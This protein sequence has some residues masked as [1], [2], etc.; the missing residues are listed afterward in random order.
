MSKVV[1]PIEFIVHVSPEYA[2]ETRIDLIGENGEKLY[3][4]I[5]K[6]YSNI[7]YYSRVDEKIKFH[8]QGAAEI[9]RLQISTF[10][11]L[12][13]VQAFN[14]VRLLLQAVGENEFTP[15][16][17]IQDRINLRHPMRND[18]INGGYLSIT[19]EYNPA[20]D[21]PVELVLLNEQGIVLGSCLYQFET[22][23]GRYQP[24]SVG[25]SYTLD[26]VAPVQLVIRQ[27][28]DRIEGLAYLYSIPLTIGP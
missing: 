11:T 3:E 4:N 18:Q 10:D 14:S 1:S 2:G 28:D 12:G 9:A 6:T 5:F 19:G 15:P 26:K 21:Q 17:A 8:I 20:N 25:F 22:G 13:R 16:F 24:F 7:G 27:P 23:N